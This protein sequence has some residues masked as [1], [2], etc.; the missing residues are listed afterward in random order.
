MVTIVP[1]D[2]TNPIADEEN[3][4]KPGPAKDEP[5]DEEKTYSKLGSG[6]NP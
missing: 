1:L 2:L 5:S 6:V 4:A 3:L